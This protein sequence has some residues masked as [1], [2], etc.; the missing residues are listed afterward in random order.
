MTWQPIATAPKDGRLILAWEESEITYRLAFWGSSEWRYGPFGVECYPTD[1]M[2]LP[3]PPQE[4]N[5]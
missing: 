4:R 3:A 2:P 1:W 5:P